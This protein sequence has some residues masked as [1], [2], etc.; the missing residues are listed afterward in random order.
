MSKSAHNP[1]AA[2]L[3]GTPFRSRPQADAQAMYERL[4]LRT[5][6]ELS[7]NRFKW[8][9][10]PE[11]I[12]PR[13]LETTLFYNGF[14]AFFY[15]DRFARYMFTKAASDGRLDPYDNPTRLRTVAVNYPGLTLSTRKKTF[16]SEGRQVAGVAV[17]V[18]SNY[19][20]MPD[21]DIVMLYA[22][23]LAKADRTIDINLENARHNKFIAVNKRNKLSM[24]NI[25]RQ[26]Q[27]GSNAIQ[28]EGMM[29]GDVIT[30]V[31]LGI[32]PEH[33][34]KIHI[35]RTRLFNEAC[36]LLGIDNSN[37]DKKE[38]LVAAEVGAND[39]QTL[40]MRYVNLNAR[41]EAAEKINKEY[42]LNVWVEY[43]T[44]V[45]KIA[46]KIPDFAVDELEDEGFEVDVSL[47]SDISSQDPNTE[48]G[49]VGEE[50]NA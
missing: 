23:R 35:I 46:S 42:G 43:N 27:D 39:D 20:R 50:D 30:S 31:D 15:D 37:Q 13:F 48:T 29:P 36:G 26:I 38:R 10:L 49:N 44:E 47:D 11:E 4:A 12:D 18:W 33:I 6:I 17:P 32:D 9:G 2:H 3:F 14:G 22:S 25:D 7:V 41:R 28:V 24:E 5:L 8:I 16:T 21:M 34:E 1:Y 40:M 19:L 45:D